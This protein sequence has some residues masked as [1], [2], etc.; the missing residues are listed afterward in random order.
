MGDP[1][2]PRV[3][4]MKAARVG[5][6]KCLTA[7]IAA[8]AAVDPCAMILLVP[9]DEDARRF[10]IEEIEMSFEASPA[11]RGLIRVGRI[12]GRNTLTTKRIVGGGSIKILA[13]R[14]PRN[15]RS[16][17]AKKLFIDEADGMEVTAD[18]DPIALAIDRT[19]AHPDRKIIIGSTPSDDTSLI[20]KAYAESDRRVYE[21]PC[22]HCGG[23]FEILW[24]HII[25][26]K[27]EPKAAVCYCPHC[28][29]AANSERAIGTD[30]L[31]DR[32]AIV[33]PEHYK[34]QM[35]E[36]G[37][38]VAQ[39]PDIEG[40]AGFHLN[41]FISLH[42]NGSWAV[43]AAEFERAKRA[44]PSELQVFRNNNEGDIW[45]STL[46]EI[47]TEGLISRVEDFGIRP[48]EGGRNRFPADALL[49][50]AG[51]DT[52]DDR[53]EVLLWGFNETEQLLLDHHVIWGDPADS[54]TQAELDIFLR[55]T[56]QHPNG[57]TIGI[58][59]AAVDSQGHKTNAVYD[60]CRPRLGRRIYAIISRNGSRKNWEPAKKRPDGTRLFMVGHDQVK[61]LVLQHLAIPP[62]DES[63]QPSPGRC[64]FSAD[65]E[66]D[67]F[68]QLTGER[69]TI[70][71]VR[72]RP[73]VEFKRTKAG[74]PV[75]A[76]D[77]TVYAWALRTSLRVN[78]AER[79]ARRG[80][81]VTKSTSL[82]DLSGL[83]NKKS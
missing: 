31:S 43:L 54:V 29:D 19:K 59:G 28:F 60:F 27:G 3:T 79:R 5:Y 16:H 46:D 35:V 36:D 44:G 22:P 34:R 77:A 55:T 75:E 72:N 56:W 33:I 52:Q 80:T 81:I 13:A 30:I 62:L 76:L 65:L 57:W 53:F 11:L 25:W 41:S 58:E 14:A 74:T 23:T 17:D 82:G 61:T 45:R 83:L 8:T 42:V 63:G 51:V 47:S 66:P 18:G 20:A 71:Y 70:R 67:T 48:G 1:L 4:I 21:V 9:R 24:K 12:D 68:D 40:H 6:T 26:P 73:V 69:R 10:A 15:L 49:L 32:P 7:A 38:W 78:F 37:H 39:K 50:V 64:R 2:I